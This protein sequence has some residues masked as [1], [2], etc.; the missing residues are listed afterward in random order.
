MKKIDPSCCLGFYCRNP[1]EF[2]QFKI[3]GRKNFSPP[4]QPVNYPMCLIMDGRVGDH[5]IHTVVGSANS[6]ASHD[7]F[8]SIKI[9]SPMLTKE[10]D[11]C[12]PDDDF[13]LE[14]D[15]CKRP[16]GEPDLKSRQQKNYLKKSKTDGFSIDDFSSK[17]NK[18]NPFPNFMRQKSSSPITR[19]KNQS[20]EDDENSLESQFEL[21]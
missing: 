17:L 3:D 9:A 13:P 14:P 1:E 8:S 21:L 19:R 12:G 16:Y 4:Q 20:A 5:R 7:A 11:A 10:F 6:D 15:E 2:E 18:L